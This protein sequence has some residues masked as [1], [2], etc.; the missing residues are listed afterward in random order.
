MIIVGKNNKRFKF[1]CLFSIN[2]H[3][4]VTCPFV[5]HNKYLQSI[6]LLFIVKLL[7][8]RYGNCFYFCF[9]FYVIAIIVIV[10]LKKN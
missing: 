1:I 6:Y 10:F 2:P 7:T 8:E 3:C 4:L 9:N 5:C